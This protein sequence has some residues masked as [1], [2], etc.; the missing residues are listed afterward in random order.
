MLRFLPLG[1]LVSIAEAVNYDVTVGK[2]TQ[3][4]FVPDS[5][6]ADVGDTI[7]YHFFAKVSGTTT[8]CTL[9]MLGIPANTSFLP[10]SF[11]GAVVIRW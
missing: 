7:T 9:L 4:K 11:S 3:L 2:D 1:L 5:L 6:Q 8:N 10:E